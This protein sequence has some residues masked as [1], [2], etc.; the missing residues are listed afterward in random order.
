MCNVALCF[1][2]GRTYSYCV[3][4]GIGRFLAFSGWI[5]K[6]LRVMS[7]DIRFVILAAL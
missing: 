6:E 3:F 5:T 2:I 4:P 7:D 1:S